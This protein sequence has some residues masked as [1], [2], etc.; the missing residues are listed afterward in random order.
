MPFTLAWFSREARLIRCYERLVTEG[1]RSTPAILLKDRRPEVSIISAPSDIDQFWT[2][3]NGIEA[4]KIT[5]GEIE[6]LDRAR[7][8]AGYNS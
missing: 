5:T 2:V 6:D 8:F 7:W 4:W 3:S 1:P